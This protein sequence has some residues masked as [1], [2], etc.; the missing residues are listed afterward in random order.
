MKEGPETR[1][2][3]RDPILSEYFAGY[4]VVFYSHD[5]EMYVR[6][7]RPGD[8]A[9]AEADGDEWVKDGQMP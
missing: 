6:L 1:S 9:R 5:K 8:K 2:Y 7:Y 4:R 3:D